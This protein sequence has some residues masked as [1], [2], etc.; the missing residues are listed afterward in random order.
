MYILTYSI[1][2]SK[3]GE[4]NLNGTIPTQLGDVATI[5]IVDLGTCYYKSITTLAC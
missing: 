4:N 2:F 1:D 3:K 5:K